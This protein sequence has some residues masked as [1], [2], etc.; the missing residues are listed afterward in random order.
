M[1]RILG[2]FIVLMMA[3]SGAAQDSVLVHVTVYSKAEQ[4]T[5]Q[6]VRATISI[7]S[8]VTFKT[9]SMKGEFWLQAKAGDGIDFKLSHTQFAS[10]DAF[11]RVPKN[12]GD[13]VDFVF[14][15]E[16]IR[17]KEMEDVYVY[18]VGKPKKVYESKRL[19]VAD[20]EIM[21]DGNILLLNYPKRLKKGSE[22]I[23]YDG[24]KSLTNFQVPSL[25]Q[26]LIRDFRGNPHVICED[27]IYGIHYDGRTVGISQADKAYYMTYIAPIVDTNL[28]RMYFSNYDPDYPAFSYYMY[29]QLDSTYR[30][31]MGVE[32]E[33]MMEHFRA[34][35][36]WS[37]VRT[38]L[39]ARN[40]EIKTGVDAEIFV[41]KAIFARSIYYEEV[42]APMFQR[43]DSLFLFDYYRDKLYTF[44][45]IGE[46][47][48]SVEI[49]HHYNP[50]TNGW[51][52][53]LIQDRKTGHIFAVFERAGYTY[54]GHI[55]TK[56]GEITEQVKLPHRYVDKVSI[57]NN[58]AYY[59][60]REF[61]STQKR[62]LWNVQLP[63]KFRENYV[64]EGEFTKVD[65]VE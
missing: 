31:I 33:L 53:Q 50:K 57:Q 30:V 64:H 37:D 2:V 45:K 60:Y 61:E 20:F 13:T 42:Y 59:V 39:W 12:A 56:T 17:L 25:A 11:K 35:Y 44:D 54:L 18:P 26:E 52:K 63:Y 47:L 65:K 51:E 24:Q 16:S 55:D 21:N 43:N 3:F 29:D 46:P 7:G 19:H 38:Q 5:V 14:E 10:V 1:K 34:E 23:I 32:D 40:M 62:M 6:N 9:T 27:M 36:K 4:E 22:L 58:S 28:T 48:D 49:Y 8:E 41:G 15:M